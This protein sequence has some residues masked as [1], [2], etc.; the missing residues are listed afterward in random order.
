[1]SPLR[2][3]EFKLNT[4]NIVT[5]QHAAKNNLTV[6]I[7]NNS[8][9]SNV[10]LTLVGNDSVNLS[11]TKSHLYNQTEFPSHYEVFVRL[12]ICQNLTGNIY[13]GKKRDHDIVGIGMCNSNTGMYFS[14]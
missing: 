11:T 5:V 14:I 10:T 1:M 2:L 7:N 4:I 3:F 13:C 12:T 6:K 9:V 8:G